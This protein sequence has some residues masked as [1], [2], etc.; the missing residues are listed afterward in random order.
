M[1]SLQN[2]TWKVPLTFSGYKPKYPL[3]CEKKSFYM[4]EH[5]RC[6]LVL[7][8]QT[9]CDTHL[10]SEPVDLVLPVKVTLR[11]SLDSGS[12]GDESRR[13]KN[14]THAWSLIQNVHGSG[15]LYVHVQS[16]NPRITRELLLS[17]WARPLTAQLNAEFDYASFV[18]HFKWKWLARGMH[19]GT[20]EVKRQVKTSSFPTQLRRRE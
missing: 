2:S 12:S 8:H 11:D 20:R 7:D 16:S 4:S 6:P 17:P 19:L 13:R 10:D 18:N 14:R 15:T 1:F 3:G 9:A 5:Q